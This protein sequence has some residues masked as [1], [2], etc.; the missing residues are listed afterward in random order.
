MHVFFLRRGVGVKLV[1]VADVTVI[2]AV[3]LRFGV[4]PVKSVK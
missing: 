2:S 4:V 3:P 1:F